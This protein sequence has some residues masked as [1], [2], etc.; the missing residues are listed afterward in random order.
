MVNDTPIARLRE[1]H[2]PC[3]RPNCHSLYSHCDLCGQGQNPWPCDVAAAL[4]ALEEEVV[5]MA[6]Q[7]DEHHS[8][9]GMHAG[10]DCFLCKAGAEGAGERAWLGDKE[11]GDE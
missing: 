1:Q 3:P 5:R 8:F 11:A 4:D 9:I 10:D 7:L 6:A 2:R